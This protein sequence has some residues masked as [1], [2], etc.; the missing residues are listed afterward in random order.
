MTN[1]GR[2]VFNAA[3][4]KAAAGPPE[5]L[6]RPTPERAARAAISD[7]SGYLAER[8]GRDFADGAD[9]Y[10]QLWE[11]STTELS[12]FWGAVADYFGVRWAQ[13]PSQVLVRGDGAERADWFPGGR[14]NYAEHALS[15]ADGRRAD[16]VAVIVAAEPAAGDSADSATG[17][18]GTG[19]PGSAD[20]SISYGE[21]TRMVAAAQA[22]LR[23][24]GVRPGDRVAALLPNGIH[25]LVAFLATAASGA[26]WSSCSPDFGPGS[27]IDRFA[28]IEPTVFLAVDGYR[29]GGKEFR[30]ADTVKQ[31]RAAIAG[32]R[33]TVIVDVLG[34]P[35]PDG[36][37][38]WDSFAD[39]SAAADHIDYVARDFSDPL[40]VLYSSGTTGLPKPIVQSVGG[41]L[42]EHL[43]TLRLQCDIGPGDRFFWFTTTGWMMWNFLVGGLL[44]GSTIVLYDGN[45]GY[46]DM[47]ALWRLAERHRVTYFGTSA[48]FIS[49]CRA[50]GLTPAAEL[51]LTAMAALGS[52][53]S[54][55]T[56]DGFRWIA[57]EI[58]DHVQ[59]CSVSGGTDLCTAV[60]GAAPTVPVWLGEISCRMLGAK[61]Q[62][63]DEHGRPVIDEV[64]ELVITEPMPSMPV[65]FWG[66]PDGSR[67]HE[68]Y[69]NVFDG[70]WRHGDWIRITE[71]G[72]CIIE[73]RS[74]ATLNRGGVRMGTAEFYRVVE[75]Q[76]GVTDSLVIDTTG[77]SGEGDLLLFVVLSD[78]AQ[79]E[80]V[81]AQLRAAI[82]SELSPRHVP[83]RVIAVPVIPRT[84]NGKKVEVPVK[85]ILAGMDVQRAVSRDALADPDGFDG[86]LA[87]IRRDA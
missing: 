85:R 65:S 19:R 9:G 27:V 87:A 68:A 25:A 8:V 81:T 42:L 18:S 59:I 50:K 48:P 26:V 51:D 72:S 1:A 63:Y 7:F 49:A 79:L 33:Q 39:E 22:G 64:G 56:T 60:V 61:V 75:T 15:L 28:Q 5:V 2:P 83:N 30:T 43:K 10:S 58:G 36:A 23:R 66:D 21:L 13:R 35:L 32:L 37:I 38:S 52:T 55:L 3:A 71:R 73:G 20:R 82:R 57:A 24:A 46:P 84:L 16:D 41:I 12:E 31:T 29:Y 40:W 77:A 4:E 17:E 86:F 69:F 11:Y 44:V 14:L 6:W 67:L 78:D 76:P 80:Q 74:D 54:P 34:D 53:G 45:P 47:M 70:V 62:A